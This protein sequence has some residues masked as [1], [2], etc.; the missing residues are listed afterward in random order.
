[1]K[2]TLLLLTAALAAGA[3]FAQQRFDLKVRNYFFAGFAGSPESLQK[4][5]ALSEE[6]LAADPKNAEAL[7][8]HGAGVYY[9][10]G[11]AFRN[12]DSEKGMQLAQQGMKEM[13]DAVALAPDQVGVRIPRGAVLLTASHYMPSPEMARPLVERGISD[14][15]RSYQLQADRLDK[16][17][18]HPRG[19]LLIGLADGY[20]RLGNEEKARFYYEKIQTDLPDTPYA[21]K[22][23]SWM[24]NKTTQTGCVGC[25]TGK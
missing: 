23:A 14:F 12:N 25:H 2:P 15:E 10:A 21:R 18:T 8:W 16:L 13:D 6:A 3:M 24:E 20:F 1:M 7:V 4:G 9:Q 17:G 22:A 11:Q 5:M 19:E